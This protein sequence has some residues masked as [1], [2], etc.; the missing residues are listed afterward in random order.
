MLSSSSCLSQWNLGIF[1]ILLVAAMWTMGSLLTQY[2]YKDLDFKSPF[3]VTYVS[4]SLFVVY[5]PV[6]KIARHYLY[7]K[8]GHPLY[9]VKKEYSLI[10]DEINDPLIKSENNVEWNRN[11][12]GSDI[13]NSEDYE[14]GVAS[15]KST[16]YSHQE[17]FRISCVLAFLWF[18]SNLL[19]SYSLLWTS[20]ASSTII[21]NLSGSFTLA[22]SY[23]VG[24]E[25]VTWSKI[26]GLLL[27]FIGVVLVTLQDST[28]D[29]DSANRASTTQATLGDIM[30]VCSAFGYGMYTAYLRYHVPNEELVSMQ[31]ILGYMGL[32]CASLI[33]PFLLI[34]IY[35]HIDDVSNFSAL[36]F[37]YLVFTGIFDYVVSDY[38]WARAI[39]LTT[40][41]VATVGLSITIPMAFVADALL[42]GYDSSAL[43]VYVVSGSILVM[44]GFVLLNL[45]LSRSQHEEIQF[46]INLVHEED[47]EYKS[48]I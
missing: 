15:A 30:A 25:Q 3:V 39:V 12:N 43:S 14:Q 46:D 21:S 10:T 40:P 44:V 27:C 34:V 32:I 4:T 9:P 48:N 28:S 5:L 37:A 17:I 31:L 45:N 24:L 2:I 16:M 23:W 35:C 38:L 33:W 8:R 13:I 7:I 41:T 20:I 42:N 6:W 11:E 36:I 22:F 19:Y 26:I 1:F 18:T 29:D 47:I